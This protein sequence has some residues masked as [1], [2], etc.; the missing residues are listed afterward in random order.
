MPAQYWPLVQATQVAGVPGPPA[1]VWRVPAAHWPMLT[2]WPEFG[3]LLYMPGG[4]LVQP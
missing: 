3:S 4:Q 2:H 1:A